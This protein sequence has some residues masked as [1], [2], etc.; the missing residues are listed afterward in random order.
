MKI[1]EKTEGDN[2]HDEE[3]AVDANQQALEEEIKNEL[4]QEEQQQQEQGDQ[5]NI[6]CTSSRFIS[7]TFQF[8]L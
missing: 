5:Q 2:T 4:E 8:F 1:Q 3:P 7:S 6:Q